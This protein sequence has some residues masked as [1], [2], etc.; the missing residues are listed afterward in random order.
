VRDGLSSWLTTGG[1]QVL[2]QVEEYRRHAQE[3]RDLA[4]RALNEEH[5]TAL[6][7]MADTWEALAEEPERRLAREGPRES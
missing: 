3:C 7:M 1:G 4:A 6:L 5:K 2:K